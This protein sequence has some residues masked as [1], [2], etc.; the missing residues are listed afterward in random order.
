MQVFEK[1]RLLLLLLLL[2]LLPP[3]TRPTATQPSV[4]RGTR[5]A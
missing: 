3:S 5:A 2:L 4:L 1:F